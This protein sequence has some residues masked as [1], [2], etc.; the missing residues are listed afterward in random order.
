MYR[1][2]KEEFGFQLTFGGMIS[3]DEITHWRI[4]AVRSLVGIQKSFGVIYD[5]RTL[6][7][8]DLAPE[9]QEALAEG[10]ELFQ[11]AGMRRSCVILDDG[12]VI[13]QYRRFA[14]QNRSRYY[15]RYIN[16]SEDRFWRAKAIGWIENDIE[17]DRA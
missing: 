1:I 11:R 7:R 5:L 13:A 14:R 16:A 4:E 6:Q 17:P 9:V 15:E 8:N 3:L 2:D 10:R 12:S